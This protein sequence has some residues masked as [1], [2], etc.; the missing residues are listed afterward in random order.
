MRVT[1][2]IIALSPPLIIEREQIS[3]LVS[4]LGDA[5]KRSVTADIAL[6]QRL[7]GPLQEHTSEHTHFCTHSDDTIIVPA[8]LRGGTH[9]GH[10]PI[11]GGLQATS[12]SKPSSHIPSIH[13]RD[14]VLGDDLQPFPVQLMQSDEMCSSLLINYQ[15]LERASGH[16]FGNLE[17]NCVAEGVEPCIDPTPL[18]TLLQH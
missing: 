17:P 4:I 5:L 7:T 16:H 11:I 10:P 3:D 12:N 9:K 8:P 2:D 6:M 13:P 14:G 1:G 15:P 18:Q